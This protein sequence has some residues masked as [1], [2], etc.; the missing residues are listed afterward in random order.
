MISFILGIILVFYAG[1]KVGNVIY[2][3]SFIK[4]LSA[5]SFALLFY[6]FSFSFQFILFVFLTF[7][8]ISV[9]VTD[10]FYRIIPVI[11]PI[12]LI[13]AGVI[14]SFMNLALGGT[15]SS[16]F[17]NSVLGILTGGG[18]LLTVGFLGHLIYKKEVIGGGDI[19]LMAGVGAFIGWEK[20]LFAVFI[21]AVMGGIAG[22]ILLAAKKI[23]KKGYIPFGPFLSTASFITLFLPQF[24]SLLDMFLYEKCY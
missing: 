12:F 24:S 3:T 9:S 15:Y 21:A 8:L 11:F 4:F 10:Y 14:F 16:R 2:K 19:K 6:R 13:I 18:V 20:A 7:S 22:L 23:E 1:F 5:F 17:I